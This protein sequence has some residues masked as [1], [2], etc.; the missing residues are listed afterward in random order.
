MC[1]KCLTKIREKRGLSQRSLVKKLEFEGYEINHYF[2]HRIETG[3]RFVTDIELNILAKA[4]DVT[5]L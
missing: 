2:I 4:L 5:I 1:G 3:E